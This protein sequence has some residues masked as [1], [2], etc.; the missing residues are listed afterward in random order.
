MSPLIYRYN[1]QLILH[2]QKKFIT[3]NIWGQPNRMY[4]YFPSRCEEIQTYVVMWIKSISFFPLVDNDNVIVYINETHLILQQK[5]KCT[6]CPLQPLLYGGGSHNLFF[7]SMRS[8]NQ[9]MMAKTIINIFKNY[10]AQTSSVLLHLNTA[11][12]TAGNH[13]PRA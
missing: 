4:H 8:L 6:I 13:T 3:Y 7:S 11:P 5:E 2:L 12:P 10:D 1:V 9:V